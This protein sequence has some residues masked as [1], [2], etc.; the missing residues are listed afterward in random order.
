MNKLI[1]NGISYIV[2]I[3]NDT[4]DA[5]EICDKCALQN[6][7]GG[8]CSP[9]EVFD[10]HMKGTSEGSCYFVKDVEKTEETTLDKKAEVAQKLYDVLDPLESCI[11]DCPLMDVCEP[12]NTIC[13]KLGKIVNK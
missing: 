8:C 6:L 11:N 7:N 4:N 1:L 2:K 13:N 10:H 12:S 9:C 3:A 5:T